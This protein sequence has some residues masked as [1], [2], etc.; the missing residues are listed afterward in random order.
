MKKRCTL[1]CLF[2]I[3]QLGANAQFSRYIVQFSN[4]KGTAYS[5]SNPAAF[6]SQRAIERRVRQ[7]IPID[8]TDLPVSKDWLDSL[9]ATPDVTIISTSKWLNQVCI[10]TT[11]PGALATINSFSFVKK[12]NGIAPR[13]SEPAH[14]KLDTAIT[15]LP[16]SGGRIRQVQGIT[17]LDY[18]DM[19]NQ[20]HI[21]EGE[22]L[23]NLGYTGRGIQIAVMDAGFQNYKFNPVFDSLR[24]QSRLLGEWDF[25]MNEA[26]VNEDNSHGALVLSVIAGNRPGVMVGSAPHASY[27]LLRTEDV[28]GEY[29]IE[30]Q[31]WAVAAEFADSA[32]VDMISSSLG[33]DT[34]DNPAF[35]YSYAQRNGNTTIITRAADM[36]AQK[37]ILVVSSAGNSGGASSELRFVGAPADGD[38]VFTVGGIDVN[39]NI[40][41]NS[42]WGPNGAGRQKPNAVSVAV[43]TVVAT[44]AGNAGSGTG[45]SFACPNLAGLMA[46]LWQAFPEFTNMEIF[47][48][49]QQSADRYANPDG[50][51][52]YGV[53]NFRKAYEQLS[54]LRIKDSLLTN[55]WMRAYPV[56]ARTDG[57]RLL[58]KAPASGR[59]TLRL[60]NA[61]GQVLETRRLDVTEGQT[62][63]E[64]YKLVLA[65]GIYYIQYDDGV[66]KR[67]LP[68][69]R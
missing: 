34:F 5:L 65:R 39:G 21:H 54:Q 24:L 20:I 58:L 6:L 42:S 66:T 50:R 38:S 37:G 23:H 56:P 13:V 45:T 62:Y 41:A 31:H 53:P 55:N 60:V 28:S 33:Y 64:D 14:K 4:K 35:N 69:M 32:G 19:F 52:G 8:S 26:S 16:P 49:V 46:C 30:E 68:V 10:Q 44:T 3:C 57:F 61:V 43:G 11:S 17:S 51:F 22:Y 67:T 36:A 9:R 7:N 25:V 29:P 27:W 2:I 48:A 18:G 15:P 47:E 12:T 59:A 1:A 40:Y 63:L